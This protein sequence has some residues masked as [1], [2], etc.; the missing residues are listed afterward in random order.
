MEG[1]E[2]GLEGCEILDGIIVGRYDLDRCSRT[3]VIVRCTDTV[4]GNEW[5]GGH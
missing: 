1:S 3:T 2:T 4:Q 5:I